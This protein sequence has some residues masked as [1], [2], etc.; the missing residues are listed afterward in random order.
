MGHPGSMD[1]GHPGVMDPS[2]VGIFKVLRKISGDRNKVNYI[3]V[4]RKSRLKLKTTK[5]ELRTN[6]IEDLSPTIEQF[7]RIFPVTIWCQG[8]TEKSYQIK[9][10]SQPEPRQDN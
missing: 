7:K 1:S 5:T 4:F 10:G 2:H 9:L 6:K 3:L 8:V